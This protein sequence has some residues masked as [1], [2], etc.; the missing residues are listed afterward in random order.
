MTNIVNYWQPQHIIIVHSFVVI[1]ISI[2][3]RQYS[4]LPRGAINTAR[5]PF[6]LIEHSLIGPAKKKGPRQYTQEDPSHLHGSPPP[7]QK[8]Y[9]F[10]DVLFSF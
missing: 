5:N 2:K 6:V 7:Q 8:H 4:L 10:L 9:Y 1:L 3:G